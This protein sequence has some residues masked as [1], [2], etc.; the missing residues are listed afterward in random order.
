MAGTLYV[1]ATPLGNLDDLSPRAAATLKQA[2]AVAGEDT[3]HTKILLA[4]ARSRGELV[5]FHAHSPES[6]LRR[7]LHLLGT[8]EAAA[9]VTYARTPAWSDPCAV[10]VAA[11]CAR[12]VP[13]V[14]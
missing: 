2:A 4:H 13:V 14:T 9:R 6:A 8:G 10:L 3:R 7:I 11:A 5:S 1:V 12:D